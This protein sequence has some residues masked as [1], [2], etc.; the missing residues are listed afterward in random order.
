[1]SS[2]V[3]TETP[4]EPRLLTTDAAARA[5]SVSPRTIMRMADRGDLPTVRIERRL[6]RFRPEDIEQLIERAAA[7]PDETRAGGSAAR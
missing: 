4:V 5:L 3:T 2:T 6:V 7:E 1:M